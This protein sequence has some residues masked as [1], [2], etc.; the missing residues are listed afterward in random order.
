MTAENQSVETPITGKPLVEAA[1]K[2]NLE[3][4]PEM[5]IEA[6]DVTFMDESAPSETATVSFHR[7]SSVEIEPDL[8]PTESNKGNVATDVVT[9]SDSTEL[10]KDSES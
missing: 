8:Q 4:L 10:H 1:P 3:P 7:M 9:A 2:D 6:E 5:T